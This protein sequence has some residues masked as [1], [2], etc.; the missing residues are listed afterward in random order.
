MGGMRLKKGVPHAFTQNQCVIFVSH[1]SLRENVQ[2]NCRVIPDPKDPC[3]IQFQGADSHQLQ[4]LEEWLQERA[5]LDGHQ[6]A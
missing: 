4:R 3:R 2:I 6:V 1:P 5:L